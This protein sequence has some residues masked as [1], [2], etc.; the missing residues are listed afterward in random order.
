VRDRIEASPR[1]GAWHGGH[2]HGR[3]T[4]NADHN[5]KFSLAD[6]GIRIYPGTPLTLTLKLRQTHMM[7][8]N[9]TVHA[10][11][12][13]R[14][15][16]M[17][18]CLKPALRSQ[19]CLRQCLLRIRIFQQPTSD[20][21]LRQIGRVGNSLGF[22]VAKIRTSVRFKTFREQGVHIH[23]QRSRRIGRHGPIFD[24]FHGLQQNRPQ[25]VCQLLSQMVA[26]VR[27]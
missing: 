5:W 19:R 17:K 25:R 10:R 9:L 7:R 13:I 27:F 2:G 26:K 3:S 14:G 18:P 22:E 24:Y 23:V 21:R 16:A 4:E 11:H 15:R 6:A 8:P 12:F 1:S 20:H